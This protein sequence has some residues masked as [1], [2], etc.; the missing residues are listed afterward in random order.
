MET[1]YLS[2]CIGYYTVPVEKGQTS[3]LCEQLLLGTS[4]GELFQMTITPNNSL[5]QNYDKKIKLD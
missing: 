5:L 4:R 3:T 1:S 2:S